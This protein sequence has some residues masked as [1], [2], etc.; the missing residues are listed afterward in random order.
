MEAKAFHAERMP[1]DRRVA[2]PGCATADR[3][4]STTIDAARYAGSVTVNAARSGAE[5]VS[6]PFRNGASGGQGP[7][8][9]ASSDK[10]GKKSRGLTGD[11]AVAP[12]D[13]VRKTAASDGRGDAPSTRRATMVDDEDDPPPTK[14]T[15]RRSARSRTEAGA[16]TDDAAVADARGDGDNPARHWSK[17]RPSSEAPRDADTNVIK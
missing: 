15:P 5:L 8:L 17:A 9:T 3:V 10:T 14:P 1:P 12:G 16:A 13:D 4:A 7:I 6:R 2:G 11:A